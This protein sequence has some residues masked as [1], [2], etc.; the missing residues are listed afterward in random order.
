MV[1]SLDPDD[2]ARERDRKITALNI[3]A[4]EDHAQRQAQELGLPYVDAKATPVDGSALTLRPLDAQRSAN[5]AL[6]KLK[7]RTLMLGVR[8]PSSPVVVAFIESLKSENYTAEPVIVSD[9]SLRHVW[10]Q[11]EKFSY[12]NT[13]I[14]GEVSISQKQIDELREQVA[15]VEQLTERI[16]A[17]TAKDIGVFVEL[18]LAGSIQLAASDIHVEPEEGRVAKVRYRLDGVLHDIVEIQ[19]NIHHL[20]IDRVKL[21]ASLKLNVAQTGQDGRFTIRVDNREIE[22][23]AS[24]LPGPNGE[25]LVLRLLDPRS[26]ID[27]PQLGLR[28]DLL[29]IIEEEL[30]RP[31]GMVLTTGPTGSGKTTMLYAFLKRVNTPDV[32]V[33]TIEDPIEYRIPG[34][35]QTQIDHEAG[36]TFAVGLRSIVRQDPD[37]ILVGEI[38]DG[39][40]TNIALQAALT[41]HLV[42]STLH[43][44]DAAGAVPR[45]IDLGARAETIGSAANAIMAQ[46]LVRRLCE[47]C[48][49]PYTPDADLLTKL[50]QVMDPLP[51]H[52]AVQ[53]DASVQLKRAPGC[54]VCHTIGYKGRIG[55][56]ELFRL[57]ETA[58]K[59]LVGTPSIAELRQFALSRGMVTLQ[60]DALLHVLHGITSIDEV[61]RVT[62]PLRPPHEEAEIET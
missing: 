10:E 8:D 46:R 20:L 2:L 59:K 48:A 26:L 53:L 19:Q 62:G 25:F 39:E 49:E 4:E 12:L 52:L 35:E 55:I 24:T 41:G 37:V 44:N 56:F 31:N 21:L 17:I 13:R 40:T 6:M 18:L 36:Y 1:H 3:K 11:Y 45:L 34:L 50:H 33:I 22:I 27:I 47:H 42:F 7:G 57:D 9:T 38:R 28:H 51:E 29:E 30:K 23:R 32:K 5:V 43:T 15:T 60:Q 61:I 54:E 58:E 14:T 16:G